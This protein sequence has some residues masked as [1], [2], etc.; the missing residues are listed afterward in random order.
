MGR[1][2]TFLSLLFPIPT[3]QT[4]R[5]QAITTLQ[6]SV[7]KRSSNPQVPSLLIIDP[8]VNNGNIFFNYN[9][10]NIREFGSQR[11]C[12]TPFVLPDTWFVYCFPPQNVE[13]WTKCVLHILDHSGYLPFLL[14]FS[15]PNPMIRPIDSTNIFLQK[16][17]SSWV[18][19]HNHFIKEWLVS[20]VERTNLE[21]S[22]L[23]R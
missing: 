23:S 8:T 3:A 5:K 6:L 21:A 13:S 4:F 12:T 11:F 1:L 17:S 16:V 7:K 22:V 2:S 9:G 15:K 20:L 18:D 14:E 19:L 10:I